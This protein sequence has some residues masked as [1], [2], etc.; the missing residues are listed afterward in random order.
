V[1]G[2]LTPVRAWLGPEGFALAV[3]DVI[4]RLRRARGHDVSRHALAVALH[5]VDTA[6]REAMSPASSLI[7]S[8]HPWVAFVIMPL[9][10]LANAGVSM[11]GLSLD[12]GNATVAVGA[13]IGL[14]LGKPLGVLIAS[15]ISLRLGVAC[16]PRGLTAR[17]VLVLGVVAGIGFTMALF[18][19]QLAF[20]DP[21]MLGAAKIGVL[22]GSAVAAA[23]GLLLGRALL[24]V[25]G[26]E[27]AALTADDA[28]A[29]TEL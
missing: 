28:E 1:V 3:R 15:F 27:G 13:A 7:E 6:R 4:D 20:A 2:L 21:A 17:H 23:L 5:E 10:A 19:A 26:Y 14:I 11:R 16:L 18:I 9:F 29:S 12:R 24:R 8:L 22:G 25:G